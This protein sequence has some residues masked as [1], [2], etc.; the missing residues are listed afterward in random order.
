MR[1]NIYTIISSFTEKRKTTFRKPIKLC[2][3]RFQDNSYCK[4]VFCIL[5]YCFCIK[6][7]NKFSIFWFMKTRNGVT[8]KL[9]NMNIKTVTI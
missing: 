7:I 4:R 9:I 6:P 5:F 3:G 8:S 1:M 2:V